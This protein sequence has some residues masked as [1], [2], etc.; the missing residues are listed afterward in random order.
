[1][2]PAS[3]STRVIRSLAGKADDVIRAYHLRKYR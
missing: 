3:A 1:M 2:D